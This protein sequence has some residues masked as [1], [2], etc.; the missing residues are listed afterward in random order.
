MLAV[1]QT[2]APAA[3][4]GGAIAA[5]LVAIV[6]CRMPV[7]LAITAFLYGS[8]YG[9]LPIGYVVFAA[10]FLYQISLDSGQFAIM[11]ASIGNLTADRRLQAILIAFSFGAL[12]EGAAAD[13]VYAEGL[14]VVGGDVPPVGQVE[15]Y[16]R[17]V[18]TIE[19]QVQ[20]AFDRNAVDDS[21]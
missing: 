13:N 18:Q 21:R 2:S 5:L 8:A 17:R 6:V 10:I 11:K 7:P 3:A 9:L 12:V 1:K 4:A 14:E 16:F 19:V 20:S 15:L